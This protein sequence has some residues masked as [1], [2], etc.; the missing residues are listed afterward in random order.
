MNYGSLI[1]ESWEFTWR[2][3]FL[4]VLG[5]FAGGAAGTS[6]G[7][8]SGWREPAR[9]QGGQP[10]GWPPVPAADQFAQNVIAWASANIALIV[11]AAILLAI[12]GLA[13]MI[14][15]L[16]AQGG[17]ARATIDI[18]EHHPMG[19]GQA[20]QAGLR[21]FWRFLAL[22]LL[23]VAITVLIG[24][25]VA[26]LVGLASYIGYTVQ[27]PNVVA[28]VVAVLIGLPLLLIGIAFG[29]GLSIVVPYA[30][31]A[32]ADQNI[33][34]VDGLRAGVALLRAHLGESLMVWLLNIALAIGAAIAASIAMVVVLIVLGVIGYL[35]WATLGL[36]TPT[37]V[38]AALGGIA[39]VAA[40]LVL[41]AIANTFFWNYWTIA[42][43][44]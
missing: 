23:V 10:E 2:Y 9:W 6:F 16:I 20:W 4:W 7:S 36:T 37:I 5:L 13:L 40:G 25:A 15:S 8:G 41:L 21:L 18:A 44:R 32:I 14:V 35:F 24:A 19:L 3:R 39:F 1:R 30:Q 33:G 11:A 22:W 29:I 28:G 12:L 38:Y 26:T 27:V 43:L 31:R 34:P 17:M 42:Y